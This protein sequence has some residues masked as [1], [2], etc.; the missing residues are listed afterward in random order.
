MQGFSKSKRL[1]WNWYSKS[2]GQHGGRGI[3]VDRCR[4]AEYVSERATHRGALSP[5]G[6]R[7]QHQQSTE[8]CDVPDKLHEQQNS[9][10]GIAHRGDRIASTWIDRQQSFAAIGSQRQSFCRH[11]DDA[12]HDHKQG[13]Y[14]DNSDR[15][16]YFHAT[17]GFAVFLE[18]Q[19]SDDGNDDTGDKRDADDQIHHGQGGFAEIGEQITDTRHLLRHGQLRAHGEQEHEDQQS[20][21][22]K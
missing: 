18:F 10:D 17:A 14:Y 22:R 7:L 8:K 21:T 2:C 20:R 16:A 3:D 11:V 13:T 15:R 5:L 12:G 1:Q 9:F 4:S 19:Q 6:K